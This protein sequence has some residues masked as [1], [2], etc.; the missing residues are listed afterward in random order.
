LAAPFT[1]GTLS[2]VLAWYQVDQATLTSTRVT[3]L[4]DAK[5][6]DAFIPNLLAPGPVQGTTANG[7]KVMT[8]TGLECLVAPDARAPW[9]NANFFGLAFWFKPSAETGQGDFFNYWSGTTGLTANRIICRTSANTRIATLIRNAADNGTVTVE[10][11]T[12]AG[13]FVFKTDVWQFFAFTVDCRLAQADRAAILLSGAPLP[14]PQAKTDSA[15][16]DA[17]L[18]TSVASPNLVTLGARDV[19]QTTSVVTG[20]CLG[21]MGPDIVFFNPAM[22]IGKLRRIMNYRVPRG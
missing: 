14:L 11:A 19:D 17:S 1:P 8:W 2:E 15:G 20:G 22:K 13:Q 12:G 6:G 3:S 18:R 21:Q 9:Q 5:G 4:P 16:I 10:S 7:L